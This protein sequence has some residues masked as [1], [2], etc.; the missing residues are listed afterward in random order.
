MWAERPLLTQRPGHGLPSQ[1]QEKVVQRLDGFVLVSQSV[2]TR[3]RGQHGA[4]NRKIPVKKHAEAS[5]E[6][7]FE[8]PFERAVKDGSRIAWPQGEYA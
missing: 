4:Q 1:R 5:F 6:P 7:R 2:G 3:P 8:P